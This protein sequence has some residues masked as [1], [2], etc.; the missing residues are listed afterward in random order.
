LITIVVNQVSY[1]VFIK[2]KSVDFKTT[3]GILNAVDSNG[4]IIIDNVGTIDYITGSVSINTMRINNTNT[5]DDYIIFNAFI[6][7]DILASKNQLIIQ[8]DIL[9]GKYENIISGTKVT[10][11]EL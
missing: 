5:P 11:S 7:D 2:D 4:L 8:D 3:N 1:D 9:F 6:V 10:V